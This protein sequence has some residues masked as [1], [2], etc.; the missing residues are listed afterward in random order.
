M[1]P[2]TT[3]KIV[4]ALSSLGV[5]RVVAQ[6]FEGTDFAALMRMVDGLGTVG[7][8]VAVIIWH[9]RD[10]NRLLALANEERAARDNATNERLEEYKQFVRS[11]G[12]AMAKQAAALERQ[13]EVLSE[14]KKALEN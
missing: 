7:V 14:I 13:T 4:A 3:T 2:M 8:L 9:Q 10:R 1:E 11:H 6:A 12:E 5:I